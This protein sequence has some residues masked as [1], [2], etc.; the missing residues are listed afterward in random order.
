MAL[1]STFHAAARRFAPLHLFALFVTI[2]MVLRTLRACMFLFG[3][4]LWVLFW[5][6]AEIPYII[7]NTN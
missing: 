5:F 6:C 7:F 4:V 1:T 3:E 2:G